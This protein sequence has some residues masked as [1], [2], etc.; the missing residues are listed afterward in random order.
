MSI[1]V[2]TSRLQD[3]Y[4]MGS[5]AYPMK[6]KSESYTLEDVNADLRHYLARLRS[7]P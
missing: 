4:L 5:I 3:G 6:D 1:T 2:R 7:K